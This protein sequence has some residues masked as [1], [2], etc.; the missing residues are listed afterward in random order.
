MGKRI[1]VVDDEPVILSAIDRALSK[2]GYEI[3][4]V[5]DGGAC[6][7]ALSGGDFS[8]VIMDLHLPGFSAEELVAGVLA[9]CPGVKFLYI[10]GSQAREDVL[11]FIQKPFRINDMRDLVRTI[12]GEPEPN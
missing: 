7:D 8:L 4:P 11:P 10:S 1:L 12:I 9:R 3:T 5:R 6:L 2:V